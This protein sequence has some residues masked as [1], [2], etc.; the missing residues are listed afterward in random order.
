[1][2]STYQMGVLLQFNEKDELTTEDLGNAT[3]LTKGALLATLAVR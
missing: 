1:M 3:S 2:C